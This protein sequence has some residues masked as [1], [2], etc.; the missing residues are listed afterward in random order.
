M[1]VKHTN[2]HISYYYPVNKKF[3]LDKTLFFDIET[4]GFAPDHSQLYLIGCAHIAEGVC[5][6][7]QYF[8]DLGTAEDERD[9]LESFLTFS[10]EFEQ[11]VT[12]NGET[13]D[14][15]YI[16]KKAGICHLPFKKSNSFDIYK[17]I[18]IYKSLFQVPN[19]KLKTMEQ[20]LGV[21]RKDKYDGKKLISVYNEYL[22][23][24]EQKNFNDLMLHNYEDVTALIRLLDLLSYD[25]FFKGR[26][27]IADLS[28]KKT[29]LTA[30]LKLE[31]HIHI[32]VNLQCP[33][34][35]LSLEAERA[36][37]RIPVIDGKIKYFY[38]N[39]KDYY[40]LPVEDTAIHKSLAVYVDGQNKEKARPHNCYTYCEAEALIHSSKEEQTD[41]IS[42]LLSCWSSSLVSTSKS[43]SSAVSMSIL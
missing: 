41:Y 38:K 23:T 39:Y 18:R 9:I 43:S 24:G 42:S 14:L 13:F 34:F 19:L 27:E 10:S 32:P 22:K 29:V 8:S 36:I 37:V 6:L 15:P 35:E 33:Q 1:I 20:F 11:L 40:Y 31:F 21:A 3:D 17:Q 5:H 16:E 7:T 12:Y 28:W 2:S 30:I 25:D 26:F 4:T